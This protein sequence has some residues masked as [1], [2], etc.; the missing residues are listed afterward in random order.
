[1]ENINKDG[2]SLINDAELIARK[3]SGQ[4]IKTSDID[5]IFNK[6]LKDKDVLEVL[7]RLRYK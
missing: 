7:N 2:N 1:M 6:L 5:K 3:Q 4:R